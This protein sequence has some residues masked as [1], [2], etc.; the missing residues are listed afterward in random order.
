MTVPLALSLS[1]RRRTFSTPFCS[2][3]DAYYKLGNCLNSRYLLLVASRCQ[4][5]PVWTYQRTENLWV[6]RYLCIRFPHLFTK[7]SYGKRKIRNN[8]TRLWRSGNILSAR[9]L[10]H[11]MF[12]HV[13]D[14]RHLSCW[15][16]LV[17]LNLVIWLDL[18]WTAHWLI[19]SRLL[20]PS[21]SDH[22]NP[23]S[24]HRRTMHAEGVHLEACVARPTYRGL[25]KFSVYYVD[26]GLRSSVLLA[27][28][29]LMPFSLRDL[30]ILCGHSC[31]NIDNLTAQCK[32]ELERIFADI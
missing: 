5:N 10:L 13:A 9:T 30:N 32:L 21:W 24:K 12:N 23:F 26:W 11:A 2:Y 31:S 8:S 19:S 7:L 1:R 17:M 28:A 3:V 22:L 15:E 27:S 18:L 20:S 25:L 14:S 16:G 29:P 4:T 6:K